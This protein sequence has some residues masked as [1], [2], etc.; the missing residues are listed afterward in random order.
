VFA[1]LDARV[2][3]SSCPLLAPRPRL[4]ASSFA[5]PAIARELGLAP[6]GPAT[7][8]ATRAWTGPGARAVEL[9]V[10]GFKRGTDVVSDSAEGIVLAAEQAL[11]A[12]SAARITLPEAL[13]DD[14][15]AALPVPALYELTMS[16][17]HVYT[18]GKY[19]DYADDRYRRRHRES[20][21]SEDTGG[22]R[23]RSR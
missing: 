21:L 23:R 8:G 20:V 17:Q 18:W 12:G 7:R 14:L 19:T 22:A 5:G 3:E 16:H 15:L 11:D 13:A 2:V 9:D 6:F 1:L 10:P 4:E